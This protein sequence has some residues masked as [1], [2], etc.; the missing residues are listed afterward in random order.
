MSKQAKSGDASLRKEAGDLE[1]LLAHLEAGKTVAEWPRELPRELE[2]LTTK[3]LLALENG[4]AGSTS[5]SRPSW[6]S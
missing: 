3:P 1:E 4:R 2:P 5:S 6:P